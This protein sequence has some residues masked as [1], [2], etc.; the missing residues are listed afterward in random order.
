[1]PLT[2]QEVYE[3]EL[4]AYEAAKAN[5]EKSIADNPAIAMFLAKPEKPALS[6]I[7]P[8]WSMRGVVTASR[9]NWKR[10]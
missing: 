9:R 5:Y 7:S 6:V 2:P 1:M 3:C 4:A 8:Y 10:R